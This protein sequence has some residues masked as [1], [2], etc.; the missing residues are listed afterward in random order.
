VGRVTKTSHHSLAPPKPSQATSLGI[1]FFFPFHLAANPPPS[2][3]LFCRSGNDRRRAPRKVMPA[4]TRRIEGGYDATVAPP[5]RPGVA[6]GDEV[7]PPSLHDPFLRRY[8][9][10]PTIV[11]DALS[12]V[13][14]RSTTRQHLLTGRIEGNRAARERRRGD[15]SWHLAG[16]EW[17]HPGFG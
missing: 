10:G 15:T 2:D 13:R 16:D 17:P 5:M 9:A 12:M 3:D 8:Q 1:V 14:L 11:G 4:T 7:T 6:P